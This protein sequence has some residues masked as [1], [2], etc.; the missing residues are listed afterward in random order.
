MRAQL[1]KQN[2]ELEA[3]RGRRREPRGDLRAEVEG[4]AQRERSAGEQFPEASSLDDLRD[5]K[6]PHAERSRLALLLH[7]LKVVLQCRMAHLMLDC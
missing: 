6:D 1:L 3:W 2:E 5:E 7:I 4:A